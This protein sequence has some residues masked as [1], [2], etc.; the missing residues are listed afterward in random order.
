[1]RQEHFLGYSLFMP[2]ALIEVD[3]QVAASFRAQAKARQIPLA[4]F[5]RQLSQQIA[6]IEIV[7]PLTEK[8]WNEAIESVT[9]DLP[10]LPSDFSRVDIYKDH[11]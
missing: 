2:T 6:P 7:P 1:M 9:D 11:D 4:D 10:V 3:E 8:E 5:L